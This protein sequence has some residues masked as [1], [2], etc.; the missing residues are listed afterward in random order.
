GRAPA[1]RRGR[2]G[3][4]DR[5]DRGRRRDRDRRH[6][7][8][9]PPPVPPGGRPARGKPAARHGDRR[10]D[11]RGAAARRGGPPGLGGEEPAGRRV[12]GPAWL[13]DAILY[14]VY[15]QSFADSDGDGVGDLRGITQRLDYLAWLGVTAV[16]L[17][18]CFASPM[19]DAGYDVAD[20]RR[21]GR[22]AASQPRG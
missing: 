1:A 8:V 21:A 15:T 20:Y 19:R 10:G 18:P 22:G 14:Q 4:A 13:S 11:E 3:L 16:W 17:N 5:G 12:A 9:A 2:P 7:R 6:R